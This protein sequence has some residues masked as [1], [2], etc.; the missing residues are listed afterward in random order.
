MRKLMKHPWTP[1]ALLMV[2]LALIVAPAWMMQQSDAADRIVVSN[3]DFKTELDE[4]GRVI[5]RWTV[6]CTNNSDSPAQ[7]V[8]TDMC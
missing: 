2:G 7:F 3:A 4:N 8:G 1:R 5:G 6:K